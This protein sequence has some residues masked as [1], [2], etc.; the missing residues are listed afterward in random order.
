MKP[1]SKVAIITMKQFQPQTLPFSSSFFTMPF[2]V[3]IIVVKLRVIVAIVTFTTFSKA[4]ALISF[5]TPLSV[6]ALRIAKRLKC[7]HLLL[8]AFVL[9]LLGC[10]FLHRYQE[11]VVFIM[12]VMMMG[13]LLIFII[14]KE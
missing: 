7:L 13:L 1:S 6:A 3:T 12:L 8:A 2:I 11:E 5:A 14:T 10:S 4:T 9:D